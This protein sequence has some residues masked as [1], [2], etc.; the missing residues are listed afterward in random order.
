MLVK[1]SQ[2]DGCTIP[3]FTH[4]NTQMI[5]AIKVWGMNGRTVVDAHLADGTTL[6]FHPSDFNGLLR[7]LSNS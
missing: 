5:C 4:I 6:S 2:S 7:R 3:E 1:I